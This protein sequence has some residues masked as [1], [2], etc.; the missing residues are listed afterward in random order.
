[1]VDSGLVRGYTPRRQWQREH[2][3]WELRLTRCKAQL[4]SLA[5]AGAD[6]Q[7]THLVIYWR[8]ESLAL[9]PIERGTRRWKRVY[10]KLLV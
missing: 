4:Q 5:G 3:S 8:I 6:P 7:Q 9:G 2:C 10:V 1:M